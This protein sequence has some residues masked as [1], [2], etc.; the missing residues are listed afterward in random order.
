MFETVN[1]NKRSNKAIL[2]L[3]IK[4]KAKVKKVKPHLSEIEES[5]KDKT[6]IKEPQN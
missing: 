3:F 2:F 4:P 6:W 5:F 1:T